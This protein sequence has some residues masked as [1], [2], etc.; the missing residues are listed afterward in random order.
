MIGTLKT[1]TIIPELHRIQAPTLI[2]NGQ[3]DE[4]QDVC[5]LPFFQRI[6]KAKWYTFPESSHMPHWEEREKYMQVVNDFLKAEA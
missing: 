4:A 3:Y 1:W 6:P 5:V 2:L